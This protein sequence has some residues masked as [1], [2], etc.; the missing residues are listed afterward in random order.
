MYVL[1]E[2]QP[3]PK[4]GENPP[5]NRPTIAQ[6]IGVAVAANLLARVGVEL[7]ENATSHNLIDETREMIISGSVGTAAIFFA[8]RFKRS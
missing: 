6:L 5:V 8:S 2:S 1:P 3:I 7:G 4:N